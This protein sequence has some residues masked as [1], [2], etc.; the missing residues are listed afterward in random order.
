MFSD[1]IDDSLWENGSR[2][3]WSTLG[4]FAMQ[5]LAVACLMLVPLLYTQS[6]PQLQLLS[7]FLELPTPPP[8]PAAVRPHSFG[9]PSSNLNGTI[10]L[11]PPTIPATIAS[12]NESELP[13]PPDVA[14][15][16]GVEGGT[17]F[18]GARNAVWGSIG[19]GANP[20]PPPSPAP[21]VKPPR[22][23]HMME[24]NL[25]YRVQPEY[26]PLARQARIQ[27]VVVLRAVISREGRIDDLQVLSGHPLLVHSAIAAVRQWRYRPYFLNDQPVEVETQVTVNFVLGGGS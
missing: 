15:G 25:I 22:V 4:S 10:L 1:F 26:P 20:L 7:R 9:R 6:L 3:G 14:A 16:S 5:I 8:A 17:G 21:N 2:R 19:A 18:A 23:S 12:F 13:P 24:G 27:G 11:Q